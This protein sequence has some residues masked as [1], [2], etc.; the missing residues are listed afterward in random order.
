MKVKTKKQNKKTTGRENRKTKKPKTKPE[1]ETPPYP[2][3]LTNLHK[4]NQTQNKT[5]A[6]E[7]HVQNL[8]LCEVEEVAVAHVESPNN[9]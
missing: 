5:K 1:T 6:N 3:F 4:T 9:M 8:F 2:S 7:V